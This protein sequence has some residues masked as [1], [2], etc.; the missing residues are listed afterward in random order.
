[1]GWFTV[2]FIT[3][4]LFTV[5]LLSTMG[6]TFFPYS[7]PHPGLENTRL[8]PCVPVIIYDGDTIG[9]DIN[10]NGRI[11]G[12]EEHIRLLGID[13]SEMHYS[14]KNHTGVDEPYALEAT[15]FLEYLILHK[16]VYLGYDQVHF[17]K[18]SRTLAFI[19]LDPQGKQMLNRILLRMGFART[20]F[21]GDNRL[22]ETDFH[23]LE[24]E[25]KAR[26][27]KMWSLKPSDRPEAFR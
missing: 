20:L 9:C 15:R 8:T 4:F 12:Q 25:A 6:Y 26:R 10:G 23:R 1:M 14:P 7:P 24:D 21:I 11:D 3:V 5:N 17:D 16:T 2:I 19:Y 27:L 18:Y 22:Y 13:T